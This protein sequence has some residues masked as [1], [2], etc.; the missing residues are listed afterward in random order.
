MKNKIGLSKIALALIISGLSFI[1]IADEKAVEKIVDKEELSQIRLK[2]QKEKLN[3][4]YEQ[5]KL[6]KLRIK[7][8]QNKIEDQI[9]GQPINSKQ[10]EAMKPTEED[11]LSKEQGIQQ[12]VGFVYKTGESDNKVKESNNILDSLTG[13]NSEGDQENPD[14]LAKVLQ[15]FDELKKESDITLKVANEYVVV[16]SL[17]STELDML[18]IYDGKKSAKVRFAYLHD[19][20]IQKRKVITVV[21]IVEGKTFKIEEDIYKVEKL[22]SDGLVILNTKTKEEIILTKNS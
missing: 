22:D 10:D 15:K 3:Q 20:G 16:K 21:S 1:T 8:E 14:N 18:S 5:E 13:N 19:D 12:N 4:E 9:T 11:I 2:I 6:N 7:Q 17:V